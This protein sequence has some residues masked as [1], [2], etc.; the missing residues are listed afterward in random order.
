MQRS[1]LFRSGAAL[2]LVLVALL[3]TTSAALAQGRPLVALLSGGTD[4]AKG[5]VD[6]SGFVWLDLNQGQGR[7]CFQTEVSGVSPVASIRIVEIS[8][9][10]VVVAVNS[11]VGFAS[12]C[13]AVDKDLVKQ[14]RQNYAKYAIVIATSQYPNGALRGALR[15]PS[16]DDRELLRDWDDL[17]PVRPV[18]WNGPVG[19]RVDGGKPGESPDDKDNGRGNDNREDKGNS[20]NNSRGGDDDDDD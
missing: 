9:N 19:E 3:I 14:I 11:G 20:G 1:T 16:A 15:L 8:S 7:I 6:G 12:G 17:P 13:V 4:S 2:L 5:D 18:G 10:R